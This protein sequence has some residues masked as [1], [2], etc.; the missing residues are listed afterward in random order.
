MNSMRVTFR[1]KVENKLSVSW[2]RLKA[3]AR[4]VSMVA[5]TFCLILHKVIQHAVREEESRIG[6]RRMAQTAAFYQLL[7]VC[8]GYRLGI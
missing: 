4:A 7:G 3:V 2:C 8:D 5:I 6:D 1:I